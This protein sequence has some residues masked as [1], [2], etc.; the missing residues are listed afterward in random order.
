MALNFEK[1]AQEGNAYLNRL[2]EDLGLEG[3]R[4]HA[5]FVLRVVLH[6]IRETIPMQESFHLLS[7]L[8][9]F[10][11]AAYVDGWNYHQKENRVKTYDDFIALTDELQ[12]R[13]GAR[14]GTLALTLRA[15]DIVL[16]SLRQ[17]VA[18]GEFENMK[19]TTP[20]ELHGLWEGRKG[21]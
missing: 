19:A 12:T 1:F 16:D 13:Y 21:P 5:G 11:K 18:P 20:P 10:L 4:D 14:E 15:I 2:A 8:P 17:Y 3:N 6:A 7:Q 9:M